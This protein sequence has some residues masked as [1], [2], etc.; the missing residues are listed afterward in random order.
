M[1]EEEMKLWQDEV[2]NHYTIPPVLKMNQSVIAETW[3]KNGQGFF[4]VIDTD[5]SD[6]LMSPVTSWVCLSEEKF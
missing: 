6:R 5:V 2:P 1:D 3:S 4:Y